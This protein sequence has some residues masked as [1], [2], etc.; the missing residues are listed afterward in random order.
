MSH[1][2]MHTEAMGKLSQALR[3]AQEAIALLAGE[4]VQQKLSIRNAIKSVL[5]RTGP[6]HVTDIAKEVQVLGIEFDSKDPT[7]PRRAVA[8]ICSTRTNE[9]KRIRPGIYGL[10]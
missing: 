9:F 4:R 5:D 10:V 6:M 8:S 1:A 7:Y 2:G 3:L